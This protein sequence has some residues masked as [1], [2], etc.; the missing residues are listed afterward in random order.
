MQVPNEGIEPPTLA[1]KASAFPLRQSGFV[2]A[3]R[4]LSLPLDST[5]VTSLTTME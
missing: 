2:G 1:C 5:P 3:V 4:G